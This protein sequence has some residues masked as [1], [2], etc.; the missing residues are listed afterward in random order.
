MDND[1]MILTVLNY[2]CSLKRDRNAHNEPFMYSDTWC[3]TGPIR[4]TDWSDGKWN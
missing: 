1:F 2:D 4:F 3:C